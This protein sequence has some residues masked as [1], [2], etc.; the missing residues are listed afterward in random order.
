V[1][2]I[3]LHVCCGVC[4]AWPTEKLRSEGYEPSWF[5]YNPNIHPREEYDRRLEAVRAAANV[6]GCPL[7]EG[8]YDHDAWLSGVAGMEGEP[9][10]G[11]RCCV[12]FRFRMTAAFRKAAASGMQLFATTL[13]VSPHKNASLVNAIGAGISASMFLPCD[14]KKED[15]FKRTQRFARE[16]MLYRQGYCGCEFSSPGRSPRSP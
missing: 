2:K 5:F 8:P 11:S 13:T 4:S 9:E 16:R 3:L 12:C 6:L 1:K 10:G 14:F 15:G 7:I